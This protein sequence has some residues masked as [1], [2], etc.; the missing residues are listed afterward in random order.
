MVSGFLDRD[1]GIVATVIVN[2]SDRR[3]PVDVEVAGLGVDGWIPYV[4]SVDS[5]LGACAAIAP[6]RIVAI[7]AR[8]IVTLVGTPH[9]R[10]G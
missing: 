2:W 3:V 5:D 10:E 7:P 9:T 4:T 1:R 6:G 8:S